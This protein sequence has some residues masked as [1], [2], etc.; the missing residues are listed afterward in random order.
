MRE[1]KSLY[2]QNSE[3]LTANNTGKTMFREKF[4]FPCAAGLIPHLFPEHE[5]VAGIG[6]VCVQDAHQDG[7]HL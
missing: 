2:S 7:P 3:F 5:N 6:V 1:W 4:Q